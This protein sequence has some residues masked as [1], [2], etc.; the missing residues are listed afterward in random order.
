[1]EHNFECRLPDRF[2]KGCNILLVD[3]ML[4]TGNPFPCI[5]QPILILGYHSF[6]FAWLISL[7]YPCCVWVVVFLLTLCFPSGGTVTAAVDLVKERG[8]EISQIRI[9]SSWGKKKR[10]RWNRSVCWL[11]KWLLFSKQSLL[12][13]YQLLL[14]LLPSRSSIK[15]SQGAFWSSINLLHF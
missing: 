1:M 12:C 2:P 9:I 14:L 15:D 11:K 6:V 8:A 13:R 3:P 10:K 7:L 5:S 4:A